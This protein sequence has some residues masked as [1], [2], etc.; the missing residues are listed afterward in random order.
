MPLIRKGFLFAALLLGLL[1]QGC[2]PKPGETLYGAIVKVTD[3][4]TVTLEDRWGSDWKI[5][6]D[7]IDA[8]ER[9]QPGGT[10]ATAALKA[11][12][13]SQPARVLVHGKDRYRRLIGT[14]Y[15][16]ELDVNLQ[17]VAD[18]HV[19]VYRKYLR[20]SA[21]SAAEAE[22]RMR[23]IGLWAL[24]EQERLPPWEWRAAKRADKGD[25]DQQVPNAQIAH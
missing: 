11:L 18:G 20:D 1:L 7:Q 9:D 14:L 5:R 25:A 8:P 17:L 22:A 6:L 19:W 23:K 16:G 2:T 3:G 10:Q 24:P 13:N 4:D 15:I 12:I 21:Y